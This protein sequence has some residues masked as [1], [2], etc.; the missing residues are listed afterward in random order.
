[1]TE[2]FNGEL[3]LMARQFRGMSQAEVASIANLD[4][5]NYSR[6]ERGLMNGPPSEATVESVARA[7]K[8]PSSFFYQRSDVAGLPLSIHDPFWRKRTTVSASDLK[9]LHAE[10]NLR[11]MHVR[12]YLEA[13]DLD[14]DLPMPRFDAEDTGGAAKVAALIR[15]AWSIPDGPIGNLTAYCERAGILVIHC[16]FVEK[17]DGMTMRVRDLP[18]LIFLNKNSP[19]DRMRHSLAHELGHLIMHTIPTDD[20]EDE[21]DTFAGELLA[22]VSQVRADVIGGRI[23]LERLVQLKMYWKVSVASLLY[24]FGKSGFLTA[25]QASYLWKQ[26]SSRGWR[27]R[28]PD[29]TQFPTEK[30]NLYQHIIDL[31]ATGMG[32]SSTD[33]SRM[34]HVLQ[35]D[36]NNLYG[37]QP[38]MPSER[39]L[40]IVK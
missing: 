36:L 1:M 16:D 40:R 10:L 23:T 2:Q 31:H 14:S 30:P 11:I 4:Q 12:R 25:N 6:L 22:P 17:V 19:A 32:Y 8:F 27:V 20:M 3:L 29:E 37:I 18:P 5:G 39:R 28:E 26:L 35:D 15:R 24:K 38:S 33:L 21:A 7:V 9:R 34:L 13:V